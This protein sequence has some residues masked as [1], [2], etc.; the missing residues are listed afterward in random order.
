M[1]FGSPY[2]VS[3]AHLSTRAL[4]VCAEKDVGGFDVAVNVT[5]GMNVGHC[6]GCLAQEAQHSL[7]RGPPPLLV[8][9]SG[10]GAVLLERE[11]QEILGREGSSAAQRQDVW[12][13]QGDHQ[14]ELDVVAV[15]LS[16][17]GRVLSHAHGVSP[18]PDV[19]AAR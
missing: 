9:Q 19:N 1:P 16:L 13:G 10:D 18:C 4:P 6:A 11:E 17:G 8:N 5:L 7:P 15:D 3:V 14:T 2:T 12:V